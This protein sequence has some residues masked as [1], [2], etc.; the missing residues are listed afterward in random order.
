MEPKKHERSEDEE[1]TEEEKVKKP[2][3]S[4]EER[5][6][7]SSDDS[8]PSEDEGKKDHEKDDKEDKENEK[9]EGDSLAQP[10]TT[11]EPPAAAT[12]I[13]T[14]TAATTATSTTTTTTATDT[15]PTTTKTPATTTTAPVPSGPVDPAQ[16]W[17]R[18]WQEYTANWEKY[19]KDYYAQ[20]KCYPAAPWA[21][22]AAA[23]APPA[24]VMGYPAGAPTQA[25]RPPQPGYPA[26]MYGGYYPSPYPYPYPGQ[27]APPGAAPLPVMDASNPQIAALYGGKRRP[28]TPSS[29]GPV[30]PAITDLVFSIHYKPN[31]QGKWCLEIAEKALHAQFPMCEVVRKHGYEAR[32]ICAITLLSVNGRTFNS[33]VW[34]REH[35]IANYFMGNPQTVTAD[36]MRAAQDAV[37]SLAAAPTDDDEYKFFSQLLSQ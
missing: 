36:I 13:T 9:T 7:A 12:V 35:D 15:T 11:S 34:V 31:E 4:E 10:S 37:Q 27:P 19:C 2:R 18:S 23:G 28:A 14:P 1:N 21:S 20:H 30:Q 22:G 24:G 33:K 3:D 8:S 32:V 17:S 16:Q 29:T 26:G 6:G 5:E 25:A